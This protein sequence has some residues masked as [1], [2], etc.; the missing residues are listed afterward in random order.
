MGE[1]RPCVRGPRR[2]HH[3]APEEGRRPPLTPGDRLFLERFA[4]QR[5]EA[6]WRLDATKIL[7]AVE[8]GL[9]VRELTNFL[10]AKN[11]GSLPQTVEVFLADMEAKSGQ[12][13]DLGAARLIECADATV[14]Q[15]LVNDRK[16][17]K[18]CQLAGDRYLVFR[19][20]D[21]AAVRRT[22]RE[23]GYVLPPT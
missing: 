2:R 10:K 22:L 1:A 13:R 20:A 19:A 3:L 4:E 15:I 23:L 5:S 14:A 8:E 9:P 18:L 16:L 6:V 12:L 17:K 7:A 21:E 11:E